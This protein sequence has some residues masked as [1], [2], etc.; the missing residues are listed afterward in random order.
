ATAKV[1]TVNGVRQLQALVDKKR[2]IITESSVRRDLHLDD[3]KGTDCL[4]T[5]TIF[6]ELARMGRKL[7]TSIVEE[8]TIHCA[9]FREKQDCTGRLGISPLLKC[10]SAIRQ[11]AYDTVYDALEEY[12]QMG[13]ATARLSLE[14]FYWESF[15]CRIAHK[16]QY[17]KLVFLDRTTTSTLFIDPLYSAISKL[18][19]A[20]E[21]PFVANDV[22]YPWGYYLCDGMYP[23][24]V[25]FVKSVTNLADDE[26]KRLRYKRMHERTRKYVERAFGA[27]K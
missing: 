26:Y 18:G 15:G 5:A 27:L 21:I 7:S 9:Y 16:A 12:L 25:S 8:V 2:V 6:E 22:T 17:C 11:L 20:P 4:P 10:P 23:E 1:Q 3:A 13:H 14:H 19:K 24:W